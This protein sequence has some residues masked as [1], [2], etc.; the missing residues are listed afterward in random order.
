MGFTGYGKTLFPNLLVG[1]RGTHLASFSIY[2][3]IPNYDK[4]PYEYVPYFILRRITLLPSRGPFALGRFGPSNAFHRSALVTSTQRRRV[5]HFF[6]AQSSAALPR[7][8]RR[9]AQPLL[10]RLRLLRVPLQA[11][12]SARCGSRVASVFFGFR[13]W[14]W[15][16]RRRPWLLI[17]PVSSVGLCITHGIKQGIKWRRGSWGRQ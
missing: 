8:F 15:A 2:Y 10:S 3:H 4:Q 7:R 9:S 13:L 1:I 16:T 14:R 17:S 12:L 6:R 5:L 11:L